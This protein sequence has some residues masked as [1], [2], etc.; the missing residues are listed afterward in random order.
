V[1]ESQKASDALGL[2]FSGNIDGRRV[3]RDKQRKHI[4]T[5]ALVE[6]EVAAHCDGFVIG[7]G[8]YDEYTLL[9]N[10]T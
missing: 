5:E 10:G 2:S 8:G 1:V 9:L 7:M 4:A 3:Q 6:R